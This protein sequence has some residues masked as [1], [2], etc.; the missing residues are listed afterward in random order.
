MRVSHS[1]DVIQLRTFQMKR[2]L[3]DCLDGENMALGSWDA[4]LNEYKSHGPT[5]RPEFLAQTEKMLELIPKLRDLPEV[6]RLIPGTTHSTLF[7]RCS[8][9][10]T[11]ILIWYD[12]VGEYEIYLDHPERPSSNRRR[13]QHESELIDLIKQYSISACLSTD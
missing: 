7:L 1:D 4:V 12:R 2:T 8:T 11:S 9:G 5:G 13:T 3:M 6:Q 10:Q